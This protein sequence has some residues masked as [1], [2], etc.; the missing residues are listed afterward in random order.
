MLSWNLFYI[1]YY[2][3]AGS[4]SQRIDPIQVQIF[5]FCILSKS[6]LLAVAKIYQCSRGCYPYFCIINSP[7]IFN[8]IKFTDDYYFKSVV[9][10][11]L[12]NSIFLILLL[13]IFYL[14]SLI[15]KNS[16]YPDYYYC[17]I[18]PLFSDFQYNKLVQTNLNYK[19]FVLT[20]VNIILNILIF[21]YLMCFI[22]YSH[23]SFWC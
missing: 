11:E 9:S 22:N 6:P 17:G 20:F 5:W 2:L 12:Q 10:L 7:S 21:K 19:E 1:T 18:F 15:K 16:Y 3:E 23:D 13:F 4:Y 14:A 8:L